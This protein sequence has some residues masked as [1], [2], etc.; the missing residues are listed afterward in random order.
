ME[1]LLA[2]DMG[3]GKELLF[4][5]KSINEITLCVCVCVTGGVCEG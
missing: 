3:L 4:L 1:A 2:F 5:G